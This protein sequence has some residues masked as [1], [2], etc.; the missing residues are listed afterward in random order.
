MA[1]SIL[2]RSLR[3]PLR[4]LRVLCSELGAQLGVLQGLKTAHRLLLF[5]VLHGITLIGSG[6]FL[7]RQF[8]CKQKFH[9]SLSN[10]I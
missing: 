10:Q 2:L 7:S 9:I 5:I 8:Q 4:L 3:F 6:L 1:M